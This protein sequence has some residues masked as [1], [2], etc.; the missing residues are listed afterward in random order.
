MIPTP[1]IPAPYV[2]GSVTL[3]A[4]TPQNLLTLIQQQITPNCPASAVEL[5]LWADAANSGS[6]IVGAASTLHGSLSDTNYAYKLTPTATPRVYRSTYPGQSVPL[7]DLQVLSI[8]G[9]S[10][11]LELW[12]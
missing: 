10:L 1:S 9:G 5:Q 4:G 12:T 7:G 11:R 8:N 3:P 6:I 2:A